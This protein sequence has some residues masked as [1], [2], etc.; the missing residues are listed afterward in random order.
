M[1]APYKLRCNIHGHEKDVRAVA[2]SIIPD[3]G[4]VS[5]SRDMSARI[6]TPDGFVL[7]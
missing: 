4:I 2:P 6:W 7:Y 1:A 5:G 3:G